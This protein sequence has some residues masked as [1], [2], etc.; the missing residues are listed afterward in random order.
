MFIAENSIMES[1]KEILITRLKGELIGWESSRVAD[2]DSEKKAENNKLKYWILSS[3]HKLKEMITR[4][5]HAV[6]KNQRSG[7]NSSNKR[8]KRPQTAR[9]TPS[10][11]RLYDMK[12]SKAKKSPKIRPSTAK[13]RLQQS[14][15]N[16]NIKMK[17]SRFDNIVKGIVK[18]RSVTGKTEAKPPRHQKIKM[19]ANRPRPSTAGRK[20]IFVKTSHEGKCSPRR[21]R[22]AQVRYSNS[23]L[24]KMNTIY[25]AY[26]RPTLNHV[27]NTKKNVS[28]VRHGEKKR[29]QNY[30]TNSTLK[31]NEHQY[32]QNTE[33]FYEIP[34]KQQQPKLN[35][36]YKKLED[37][38]IMNEDNFNLP[39][40][41]N[42]RL[43][44]ESVQKELKP[45]EVHKLDKFLNR[46]YSAA[47]ET[48]NLPKNV[49]EVQID[50][51]NHLDMSKVQEEIRLLEKLERITFTKADE[52]QGASTCDGE[53]DDAKVLDV[54]TNNMISDNAVTNEISKLDE[55]LKRFEKQEILNGL[56]NL[57]EFNDDLLLTDN[58][59]NNDD[60]NINSVEQ[61]DADDS[62]SI[63]DSN[64]EDTDYYYYTEEYNDKSTADDY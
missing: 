40:M 20:V 10:T 16:K 30:N 56:E 31:S 12:S 28:P 44:K 2:L 21:P 5:D 29:N 4:A 52:I 63:S 23:R 14:S 19:F 50:K 33:N 42:T 9:S 27:G 39:N 54:S 43:K 15:N 13:G 11:R 38:K 62:D 24:K 48:R 8:N 53:S 37:A 60:T 45:G 47:G 61:D 36:E 35:T 59:N 46:I 1:H 26:T 41:T 6:A 55:M 7:S 64:Q 58:S 34:I 22:S 57:K 18:K 25:D 17:A 32:V 3:I 49:D 51:I